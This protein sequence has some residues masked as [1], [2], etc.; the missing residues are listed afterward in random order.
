MPASHPSHTLWES[1]R[2]SHIPTASTAQLGMQ[3][4]RQRP[5]ITYRWINRYWVDTENNCDETMSGGGTSKAQA[6]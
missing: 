6:L 5:A 2:D 3:K 4:Q 1:L